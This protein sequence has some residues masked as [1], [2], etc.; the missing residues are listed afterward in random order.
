MK[1]ADSKMNK[2]E[3]TYSVQTNSHF[4]GILKPITST[5]SLASSTSSWDEAS[6]GRLGSAGESVSSLRGSEGGGVEADT[7]GEGKI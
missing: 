5:S 4:S 6:S 3:I 1:S 7:P 2:T